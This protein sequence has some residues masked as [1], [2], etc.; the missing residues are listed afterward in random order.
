MNLSISPPPFAGAP[1]V[2]LSAGLGGSGSYWLPQ[3]ADLEQDYQ[4][5]CYDQRGTG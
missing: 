4:V 2:V 3:L 1:V 5:V